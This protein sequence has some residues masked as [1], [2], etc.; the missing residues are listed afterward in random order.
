M[1]DQRISVESLDPALLRSLFSTRVLKQL[2]LG[3]SPPEVEKVKRELTA[4]NKMLPRSTLAEVYEAS[5]RESV[6]SQRSEY[7]YKN[8]IVQKLLLGKYSLGTTS[9][10]FEVRIG[11][12]KL[13]VLLARDYLTAFEI[14]TE[15]DEL[16]RLSTQVN[17]YGKA[18]RKIWVLTSERHVCA[19]DRILPES[20]GIAVLTRKYQIST[21]R[22][23]M[24]EKGRLDRTSLLRLLRK[25]ELTS[26][27]QRIVGVARVIPNTQL[28]AE[29]SEVAAHEPLDSIEKYVASAMLR[30]SSARAALLRSLPQSVAACALAMDLTTPQSERLISAFNADLTGESLCLPTIPTFEESNT[31]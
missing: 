18:C 14:K 21:R 20:V 10:G 26:L 16:V 12:S 1:R 7:A 24:P 19:V 2:A 30:R 8:A 3:F 27:Y 11:S 25:S 17:D 31:N 22:E 6:R 29:L 9:A 28:F 23:A 13:D 5:F 4:A 15:R